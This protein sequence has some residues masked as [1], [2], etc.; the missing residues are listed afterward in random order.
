MLV[1]AN[2]RDC[3]GSVPKYFLNIQALK[4]ILSVGWV[5]DA[6]WV[7]GYLI[8]STVGVM[9]RD[10]IHDAPHVATQLK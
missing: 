8:S 5:V 2:R 3:W 7:P 1:A 4:L 9:N 6:Y 10:A